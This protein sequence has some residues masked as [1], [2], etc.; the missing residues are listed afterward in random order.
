MTVAELIARLQSFAPDT[1]VYTPGYEGGWDKV[2]E[3]RFSTVVY[4]PA[5]FCGD[6]EIANNNI[7][8]DAVLIGAWSP[9]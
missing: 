1:Q 6:Y 9:A 7:G 2:T 8:E 5:E 3:A 4:E